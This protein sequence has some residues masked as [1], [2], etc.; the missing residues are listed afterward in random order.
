MLVLYLFLGLVSATAPN[1]LCGSA[2]PIGDGV[3]QSFNDGTTFRESSCINQA[4]IFFFYTA[5]C[6]GTATALFRA[7]G[8]QDLEAVSYAIGATCTA[9]GTEYG[10]TDSYPETITTAVTIGQGYYLAVGSYS[11]YRGIINVT[12]QCLPAPPGDQCATA[13]SIADGAFQVTNVAATRQTSCINSA[14]VFLLYTASCTGTMV[15]SFSTAGFNYISVN[16]FTNNVCGALG[17]EILCVTYVYTPSLEVPVTINQGYYLAVGSSSTYRGPINVT[18]QCVPPPPGDQCA[19]A[20]TIADGNTQVTNYGATRQTSCIGYADVYLYYTA[21]CTGTASVSFSTAGFNYLSATAFTNS[22]CGA[23]GTETQCTTYVYNANLQVP[24]TVNQG[25]YFAVGSSDVYRGIINVTTQCIPTPPGDQCATAVS[26]ADGTRLVTNYGASKQTTSCINFADVYLYYTAP[27]T[28]VVIAS[29]STASGSNFLSANAFTSNVCGAL[30][31]ATPCVSS[32]TNPSFEAPVTV[33]QG[34]YF[35]VG[36]SSTYRGPINVTMQCVPAP[37]GDQCATAV[38]V[39]D[40]TNQFTNYGATKQT[41]CIGYADVFS[42]YTATCTGLV[43]A[44]FFTSPPNY[45][46]A[47]AFTSSVCAALPT[48]ETQCISYA[49]NPTLQVFATGGQGYYLAVG[50][51]YNTFRGL[52]N[53]TMQCFPAPPNDQC[54]GA[55]SI[56]DGTSQG[57]N[58][59]ASLQVNCIGQADIFFQYVA[60]CTGTAS[61]TF[62]TPGNTQL[63]IGASLGTSCGGTPTC[64]GALT[65]PNVQFAVT[66]GQSYYVAVGASSTYRGAITVDMQCYLAPAEDQCVGAISVTDG[67]SHG[68]NTWATKHTS[69]IRQA[70]IYF[71]YLATCT[72][73]AVAIFQAGGNDIMA[74]GFT[75]GCANLIETGCTN[76]FTETVQ[77][78]VVLGQRYYFAAGAYSTYRGQIDV[79]MSCTP[80]PQNDLCAGA[81]SVTDGTTTSSNVGANRETSCIFQADIFFSYLA[82]CTGTATA[83]FLTSPTSGGDL[84]AVRVSGSCGGF[85]EIGC[86]DVFPETLSFAV[87]AGSRYTLAVGAY[88]TYRGAISVTMTCA[89]SK[90]PTSRAPTVK[91]P[92][93]SFSFPTSSSAGTLGG[94]FYSVSQMSN[95]DGGFIAGGIFLLIFLLCGFFVCWR[96]SQRSALSGTVARHE[97]VPPPAGVPLVVVAA[98]VQAYGPSGGIAVAQPV[99]GGVPPP[100][101]KPPGQKPPPYTGPQ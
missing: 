19:T 91:Q 88:S 20:V 98:P 33:G 18:T 44:S 89:I 2:T 6:T 31:S 28:G 9:L 80:A 97:S 62:G 51:Y 86:T 43:V 78:P 63:I 67:T 3:T 71:S 83:V 70:D 39:T 45:L 87:A 40:G 12:M 48:S 47:T 37:P 95:V 77:L 38:T 73:S 69:C 92:T 1:D 74:V 27:C 11:S 81:L 46:S 61:A 22:V 24:V 35:A 17:T 66:A 64:S 32:V 16:A 14:D 34:Y 50:S 57:N 84:R 26:I 90:A 30:G 60:T 42:L 13:V 94:G 82:T 72:G 59:Y 54:A 21:T 85:S 52:I 68:N 101:Q 7:T 49:T 23:L 79:T 15:A 93:F 96:L 5:S 75:G 25:Y 56:T 53:V 65:R 55:V 58:T 36:S 41:S 10:C 29:F 99:Y 100:G 76:T 8:N 4:D